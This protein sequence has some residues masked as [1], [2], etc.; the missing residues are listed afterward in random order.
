M[1]LEVVNPAALGA[2]KGF[3]HGVLAPREGRLLFVAGMAGWSEDRAG[4]APGFAD[5]FAR[6][7]DQVLAVV[8]EAG[9]EAGDVARMTVYVTDLAEYRAARRALGGIWRER[10]GAYYP[11]M[12]V[13]EVKA[14]VD[15]GARVEI[16]ATA[17][18]AGRNP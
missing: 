14:L 13:L 11:A 3:S 12:A 8:R 9:G 6:A 7:L 2:P 18:V 15:R 17:V 10:F 16:E 4:E 1:R 5:Q